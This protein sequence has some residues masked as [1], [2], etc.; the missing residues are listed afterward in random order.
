MSTCST[1]KALWLECWQVRSCWLLG[2]VL[3]F[4]LE[5]RRRQRYVR[6]NPSHT[7]HCPTRCCD[8]RCI[9]E[10]GRLYAESVSSL[11]AVPPAGWEDILDVLQLV[12]PAPM[13]DTQGTVQ[14]TA[15]ACWETACKVAERSEP[16]AAEVLDPHTGWPTVFVRESCFADLPAGGA[17][18][19]ART[20][21]PPLTPALATGAQQRHGEL[22]ACA[23]S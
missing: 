21:S 8:R 15:Q 13:W 11:L 12:R 9:A 22:P 2:R 3:R 18:Q 1:C 17:P 19:C 4:A 20:V 16:G 5:L 23:R 10:P 14:A 6:N 7:Q